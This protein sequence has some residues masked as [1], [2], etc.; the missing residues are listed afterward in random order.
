VHCNVNVS[1]VKRND[2]ESL[3]SHMIIE[4]CFMP[5]SENAFRC[6]IMRCYSSKAL[7]I[8]ILDFRCIPVSSADFIII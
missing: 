3:L 8:G 5:S 2:L 1:D 7:A 4:K 6:V